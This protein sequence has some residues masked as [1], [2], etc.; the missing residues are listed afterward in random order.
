MNEMDLAS[1]NLFELQFES[2]DQA[3]KKFSLEQIQIGHGLIASVVHEGH[4]K[5]TIKAFNCRNHPSQTESE[6]AESTQA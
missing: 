1:P 5:M 2:N 4:Q 3:R 6:I